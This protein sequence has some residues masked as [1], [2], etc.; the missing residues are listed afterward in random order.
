MYTDNPLPASNSYIDEKEGQG[1]EA[2][3]L[4]N[5]RRPHSH[6]ERRFDRHYVHLI[7]CYVVI[8]ALTGI[9]VTLL[10]TLDRWCPDPSL[11]LYCKYGW[12]VSSDIW[13]LK[14]RWSS[15][16]QL[17]CYVQA[18]DLQWMVFPRQPIYKRNE[19]VE[20]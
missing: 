5:A 4:L 17:R 19:R 3:G 7:V 1:D 14:V 20:R 11:R 15:S 12:T 18:S 8:V 13:V 16:S 9:L 2:S 6:A 10:S